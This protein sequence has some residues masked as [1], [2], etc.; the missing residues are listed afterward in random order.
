MPFGLCNAPAT[1][2]RL[3]DRVLCGMHWSRCLVY[4]EDVISFGADA[5]EALAR[6]TEVLER[7]SSFG[8]Q[9]KAKKC[10]FIQ[11]EVA[12][13]GHIMVRARLACDPEK[14][15]AV[16][17]WHTPGSVEQVR[18]FVGFVG[19]YHRFIQNFAEFS[20]PCGLNSQRVCF[21]VDFAEA[22]GI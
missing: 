2:E 13:L 14:L 20:E 9:L 21:R 4:L 15:S 12:F 19:Y 16:R 17:D 3:M 7:L 18:Q 22:G 11:T 10:T 6:L 8:L 1:F 5:P